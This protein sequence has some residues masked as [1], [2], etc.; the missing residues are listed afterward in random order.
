MPVVKGMDKVEASSEY[1]R[2]PPELGMNQS[3]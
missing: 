2:L 1:L 3:G